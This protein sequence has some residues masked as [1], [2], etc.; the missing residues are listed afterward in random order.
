[1]HVVLVRL[2]WR[3][4]LLC[5]RILVS[6]F[7]FVCQDVADLLAALFSVQVKPPEVSM[8]QF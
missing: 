8:T 3:V 1:M 4:A 6:L 5:S 7:F 2:G